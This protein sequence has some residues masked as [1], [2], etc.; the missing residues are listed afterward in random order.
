MHFQKED[1]RG[2]RKKDFH[3]FIV[4]SAR[5]YA[6]PLRCGSRVG[7]G[8]KR[9]EGQ[10]QQAQRQHQLRERAVGRLV[11]MAKG[12]AFESWFE[13]SEGHAFFMGSA[14][15]AV[16]AFMPQRYDL[17]H[18]AASPIPKKNQWSRMIL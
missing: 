12:R 2:K 7:G 16:K 4:S 15:K 5:S 18:I 14:G 11:E 10:A 3:I 6:I 1:K 13:Y 8:R 17:R 9:G